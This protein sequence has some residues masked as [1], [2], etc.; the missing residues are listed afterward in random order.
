[1]MAG[2]L[3]TLARLKAAMDQEVASSPSTPS[4][5]PA[6]D[7]RTVSQEV[8]SPKAG[9]DVQVALGLVTS[10]VDEEVVVV[11]ASSASRKRK[12]LEE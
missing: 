11:S 12:K 2:G 6:D 5:R 3:T 8:A 9:G 1:E 10:G 7:S 4:S